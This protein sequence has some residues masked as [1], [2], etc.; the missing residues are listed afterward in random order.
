MSSMT[1]EAT[2]RLYATGWAVV[3]RL[4]ERT[5]YRL[6][7]RIADRMWKKQGRSV[8][9]LEQNLAR[10]LGPGA[11]EQQVREVSRQ[12][13]RNYLRYWCETFR[14]ENWDHERRATDFHPQNTEYLKELVATG[15]G[16]ILALPHMANWD[17]AGAWLTTFEPGFTTVAERLK[18]EKLF[19][20]FLDFRESLG[21][22]VLPLTGGS[23]TL[24]K[25]AKRLRAGGVVC[26]VADRD[27]TAGGV[28]VDFFGE[29]ATFPSG[30]ASL[31]LSTG[32]A[33]VPVTLWFEDK[34]QTA[35]FHPEVVPPIEGTRD[36]KL[37]AM[38]RA[39]AATFEKGIGEHPADW[40]MLQRF[41]LADL[42]ERAA[43][44]AAHAARAH[45]ATAADP[46]PTASQA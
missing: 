31:A 11:T 8:L 39:V 3:K 43:A 34:G 27:L 33:L 40:H 32:A 41:W 6:F 46:A 15:R 5:A 30:S 44:G 35:C 23:R 37:A 42:P 45:G 4:P 20:R 2:Y 19:Q 1:D 28:P 25:L 24:L 21:F 36:Q 29:A 10:V 12:S 17:S 7:E 16:V 9:Q 14:L 38:T 13:L 22:E 18:P 26:L